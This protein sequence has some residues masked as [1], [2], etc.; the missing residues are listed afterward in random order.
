MVTGEG[1]RE[2]LGGAEAE[3]EKTESTESDEG[4]DLGLWSGFFS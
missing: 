3:V 4:I 1:V 2:A